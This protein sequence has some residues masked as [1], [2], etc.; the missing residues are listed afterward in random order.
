MKPLR[1]FVVSE[2]VLILY[3][4]AKEFE[5]GLVVMLGFGN[6]STKHISGDCENLAGRIQRRHRVSG[7]R[8]RSSQKCF[9]LN[10]S[11]RE[12]TA[13]GKCF[14]SR[15]MP[16]RKR[17]WQRWVRLRLLHDL[18]PFVKTFPHQ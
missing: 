10:F 9:L 16:K 11:V 12:I 5:R 14:A 3:R 4:L 13:G 2:R 15:K 17:C 6:V 18:F 1:W 8:L 7:N